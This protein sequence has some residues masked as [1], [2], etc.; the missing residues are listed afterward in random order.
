[1]VLRA[2][3]LAVV[4]LALVIGVGSCSPERH[5]TPI[6]VIFV[7]WDSTRADHLS[8]YG[9]PRPTTPAL[10]ALAA[11][12]VRFDNAVAQHNWTRPSYA[13]MLTSMHNWQFPGLALSSAQTT[14]SEILQ[15]NGYR[16]Q[17]LVQ[18]P[19]LS[20]AYHFDQGF[21]SY[22]EVNESETPAQMTDHAIGTLDGL[23]RDE[24]PFFLFLHYQGPHYPYRS[25]S[26]F[27]QLFTRD[28][29]IQVSPDEVMA[30]MSSHGDGWDPSAPDADVR[31]RNIVD[32]YDGDI[33][34]TDAA[35]RTLLD[36]LKEHASYHETLI[37]FNADHGDEFDDRGSFGHAHSNLYPELVHVPLIVRFPDSMQVAPQVVTEPVQNVDILPTVLATVGL[38]APEGIAGR[39]LWPIEGIPST[40]RL[41]FSNVGRVVAVRTAER[42]LHADLRGTPRFSFY[43][44]GKDPAELHP[45]EPPMNDP[46][47]AHLRSAAMGWLGTFNENADKD[48]GEP[49]RVDERLLQRLRSLGYVR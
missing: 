34:E 37:V 42:A 10:T 6:N 32:Q 15:A 24:Q 43:D 14:L 45:L 44:R 33:R 41:T 27:A 9:Y 36:W 35:L 1:M 47:F 16:T 26:R 13:S 8:A 20:A 30:L 46:A 29:S 11:D 49:A 28:D 23:A 39:S 19:N 21:D 48:P 5:S 18:N 12:A 31:L 17:G 40:R 25:T 38:E 22:V 4:W 7:T 3:P 2:R